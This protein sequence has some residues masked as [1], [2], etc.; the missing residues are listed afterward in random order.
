MS[1]LLEHPWSFGSVNLSK[2]KRTLKPNHQAKVSNIRIFFFIYIIFIIFLFSIF[3]LIEILNLPPRTTWIL[4]KRLPKI[5][6]LLT[7]YVD[8]Y[9]AELA[10]WIAVEHSAT[11]NK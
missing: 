8:Q 11:R 2:L 5:A 10:E 1:C 9:L 3:L 7:S 6:P 4:Y